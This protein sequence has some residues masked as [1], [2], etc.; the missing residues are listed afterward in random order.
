MKIMARCDGWMD[1]DGCGWMW[2][3]VDGCGWIDVDGMA[4]GSEPAHLC[5]FSYVHPV[6]ILANQIL[7]NSI[8]QIQQ[9]WLV[10]SKYPPFMFN[11]CYL[12]ANL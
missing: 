4:I 5:T 7:E 3:D 11:Y 2:M 1:V 6:L 9:A 8:S 10:S 12:T